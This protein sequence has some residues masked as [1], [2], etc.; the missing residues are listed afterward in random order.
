[1]NRRFPVPAFALFFRSSLLAALLAAPL[2]AAQPASSPE[3]RPAAATRPAP[4]SGWSKW[5]G[6]PVL[7][8]R[9]G[10]CFDVALLHEHGVYRL[11]FSWRPRTSIAVVESSDGVHW[12]EPLIAL[13]PET[14]TGWEN[15]VNRPVVVKRTDGYHLWYTGQPNQSSCIG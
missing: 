1:M 2:L 12:N 7:G 3:T 11:W 13:A 14:R 15:D 10:T 4:D 5:A 6:N 9:V 8:G